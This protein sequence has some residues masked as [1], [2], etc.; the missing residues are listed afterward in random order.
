M[1]KQEKL[2]PTIVQ[3]Y[4]TGEV[5]MLAYSNRQSLKKVKETKGAWFY[6]RSRKKLWEKGEESGNK[7]QVVEILKDCDKDTL[8]F[9]VIPKGPACHQNTRSCFSANKKFDAEGLNLSYIIN[10]LWEV[11]LKRKKSKAENSYTQKLYK[12]GI[13]KINEK[14]KEESEELIEAAAQKNNQEVVWE[15]C[16]LFYHSLVLLAKR[17]VKLSEVVK[18]LERRRGK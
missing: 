1:K 16:D 6:S 11:L 13:K 10:D 17:N 4:K 18:E 8:L 5:L 3:D 9:K 2:T 14:I 15:F 7:M 12:Q